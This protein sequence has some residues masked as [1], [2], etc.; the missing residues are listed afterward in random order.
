MA[1]LLADRV[2]ETSTSP[3]GTGTLTLTGSPVPGYKSFSNGIGTGNSL[4]YTIYDAVTYAWEVGIGSWSANVLTRTTVLSNSLNTTAFISFVNGNTLNVWVDYPASSAVAQTDIGTA[5][6]QIPLN[7]YLGSMAYQDKAGVNITGGTATLSTATVTTGTVTNLTTTNG[8]SIQTLTVGLGNGAVASNTA[9]GYQAANA[10]TTGTRFTA[11]G[12]QAGYSHTTPLGN[13]SFGYSALYSTTTGASNT[14]LGDSALYSA[15]TATQCSSVGMQSLYYN[16]GSYNTALGY[17]ALFGVTGTSTGGLNTAIG[18]QAGVAVTSGTSSVFVGYQVAFA[19]TTG[20]NIVAVGYQAGFGAVSANANTTGTNNTYLGY[21]TVGS[22]ATNTNEM[23]IGYTAVGLGSNTTVIGNS[24]T[25]AT[26]IYGALTSSS[27]IPSS[28]TVPTNGVYL[29]A[30]NSV[31]IATA[32]TECVRIDASG[33]L[34]VG[35][36]ATSD[37]SKLYVAGS[38]GTSGSQFNFRPGA[39]VNYQ[40][41]NRV[42]AGF[43]FYVNNATV[44]ATRINSSGGLSIGNTVDKGSGSLNLSG[45]MFPQQAT[46]AAAPAYVKG[47]IYF[48]TTL[49]KLRVGGATAWETITSV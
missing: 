10:N 38:I 3:G 44:L 19:N 28:S 2:Q 5:P 23:V 39:S 30:T 36:T 1:V 11:V 4:Y 40:F 20:S 27:F 6:N 21:Q 7:Q 34:L 37:S 33:N 26:T 18:T 24:S 29:P 49:N 13:S 14:A 15:V 43:D 32:S 31:G 16:T 48:D 8:A 35:V 25:T 47:A 17:R 12:Y 22:A 41:V 46:T 45:L 42:G 9:I